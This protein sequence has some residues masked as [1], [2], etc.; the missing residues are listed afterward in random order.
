MHSDMIDNALEIN[1]RSQA[2]PMNNTWKQ[3]TMTKAMG[4]IL[5][6]MEFLESATRFKSDDEWSIAVHKLF[7]SNNEFGCVRH[8]SVK[9][10]PI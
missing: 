10:T 4:W 9:P 8:V 5:L 6:R 1:F 2:V 3:S 7:F